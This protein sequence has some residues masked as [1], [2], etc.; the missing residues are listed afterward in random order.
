MRGLRTAVNDTQQ[1][2]SDRVGVVVR[3]VARWEL[4]KPPSQPAILFRVAEVSRVAGREDLAPVFDRATLESFIAGVI[5]QSEEFPAFRPILH[6]AI[7][8]DSASGMTDGAVARRNG[9]NR[10]TVALCARKFLQFGLEA[11]LGE[12]PRPGKSRRIPDDAI[13]WVLHCACQK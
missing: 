5:K 4:E 10:H 1:R 6:A 8:L 13:A 11:A 2:F 9:V 3:T 7:L 12:L